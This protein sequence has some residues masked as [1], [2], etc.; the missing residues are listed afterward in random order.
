MTMAIGPMSAWLST[1][2]LAN[3]RPEKGRRTTSNSDGPDAGTAAGIAACASTKSGF[4]DGA[5]P[6]AAAARAG[7]GELERRLQGRSEPRKS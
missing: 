7:M 4:V 2:P 1:N 5:G 3:A 6:V